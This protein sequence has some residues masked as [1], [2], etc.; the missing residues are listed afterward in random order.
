MKIHYLSAMLM[1]K[2]DI[3]LTKDHQKEFAVLTGLSI[4]QFTIAEK[5][6]IELESGMTAITGETGAGKSIALD[7]LSLTLGARADSNYVR[8]GAEKAD[9]RAVFDICQ[10]PE[11]VKWLE[12]HE[13]EIEDDCILRRIVTKEGRSKA[14]I[15][16]Q[17]VNL[18]T[19][20]SLG[21]LLV[22]IHSQHAHHQLLQRDYHQSLLDAYADC[23]P[24]LTKVKTHFKKW[25]AIAKKIQE[26]QNKNNEADSRKEYIQFQLIEF[27]ELNLQ[28]DE[29]E[30]L[31]SRHSMM[32]NA[33]SLQEAC[34]QTLNICKEKEHGALIDQ[35]QQCE[36]L[37]STLTEHSSDIQDAYEL[38]NSANIQ[39]QEACQSLRHQLDHTNGDTGN[40]QEIE[41]RLA[42]I[43]D[44]ARKHRIT[45]QELLNVQLSL[46]KEL[47]SLENSKEKIQ[48]LS[49]DAKKQEAIYHGLARQLTQIRETASDNLAYEIKLQLKA[50]GMVNCEFVPLLNTDNESPKSMGY[51]SVEF[52]VSTNPGL[53]PQGLHK[54]ASGGELSRISL[55][56]QVIT[57]KASTIPTLVFDE[58][59]V[60]IGGATAEVVGRLLKQLGKSAQIICVT[61]QPQVAAQANQHYFVAKTQKSGSTNTS[62]KVLDQEGKVKEVARMLGGKE[63]TQAT[64]DHAKEMLETGLT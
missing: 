33:E 39:I 57:A 60:G 20:K 34:Q 58:V 59:D 3:I 12:K 37:L 21:T 54:I 15:N 8:Y 11:A 22:D 26:L 52:L 27:K 16:G 13:F 9:I 61:H 63:I 24:L 40:L 1:N 10:L 55:A 30:K 46:K 31:E 38:I 6:N 7:A 62:V 29:Y 35:L 32:A 47:H 45:P 19:L 56:I 25:Q 2:S 14:F 51:E 44:L 49:A 23:Q 17:P 18:Q 4:S 53:P 36:Q 50:L 64:L 43:H 41:S 42:S 5:L 28:K 48:A